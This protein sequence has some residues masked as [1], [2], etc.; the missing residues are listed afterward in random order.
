M[1]LRPY[2]Q[3]KQIVDAEQNR[4]CAFEVD[5]ARDLFAWTSVVVKGTFSVLTP[6]RGSLH[7]YQQ[8]ERR[9]MELVPGAFSAADPAPH[10]RVLFG[11]FVNE[12]TGR[13][14]RVLQG[15]SA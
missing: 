5:D 14:T 3:G 13:A 7:T 10:R 2:Q 12:M 1:D 8:A 9:L 6:A 15:D 11:I 4:W